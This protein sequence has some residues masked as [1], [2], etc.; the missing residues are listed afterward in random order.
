VTIDFEQ[1][2]FIPDGDVNEKELQLAKE[3][4]NK[5][6]DIVKVHGIKVLNKEVKGL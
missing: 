2:L 6:N 4:A 3:Y 1:K 5:L